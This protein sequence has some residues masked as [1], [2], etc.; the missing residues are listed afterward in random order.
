MVQSERERGQSPK[1]PGQGHQEPILSLRAQA[2][3]ALDK[4]IA[5]HPFYTGRNAVFI[6]LSTP[7]K[8]CGEMTR[9]T[10]EQFYQEREAEPK[11]YSGTPEDMYK[12]HSL[13]QERT[14]DEVY[15][16]SLVVRQDPETGVVTRPDGTKISWGNQ[17][18]WERNWEVVG[19][20]MSGEKSLREIAKDHKLTHERVS[21]IVESIRGDLELHFQ[22]G[23]NKPGES[24]EKPH[25]LFN[26]Q[27]ELEDPKSEINEFLKDLGN[28]ET[29]QELNEKYGSIKVAKHRRDLAQLGIS[30]PKEN[31][32]KNPEFRSQFEQLSNPNIS[33]KRKGELLSLLTMGRI[34]RFGADAFHLRAMLPALKEDLKLYVDSRNLAK[35]ISRLK[36]LDPKI[37]TLSLFHGF[38][39]ERNRLVYHYVLGID[40]PRIQRL[41]DSGEL[42]EYQIPAVRIFGKKLPEGSKMTTTDI[43]KGRRN[44]ELVQANSIIG[45]QARKR[46]RDGELDYGDIIGED[47][48]GTVFVTRAGDLYIPTGEAD[49]I[50]KYIQ[51]R[52]K[53][54][55]WARTWAYLKTLRE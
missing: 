36:K 34:E 37:Y 13:E 4:K 27:R 5:E 23:K 52:E 29:T 10:P 46:I 51:E 26:S 16:G 15:E 18:D 28:G 2:V 50:R 53:Q 35:F 1:K 7:I 3:Q 47:C 32:M 8:R 19:K 44:K 43:V 49:I 6:G 24:S 39:R 22:G 48:P 33:F 54:L 40:I 21:Q 38:D 55:D 41:K 12:E 31:N 30:V 9:K 20:Y 14:A 42:K 45:I 17:R 25:H 11:S